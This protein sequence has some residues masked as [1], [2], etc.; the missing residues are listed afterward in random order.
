[1]KKKTAAIDT[2]VKLSP[3]EIKEKAESFG[4]R[5]DM[6]SYDDCFS[7]KSGIIAFYD[8]CL[9]DISNGKKGIIKDKDENSRSRQ[10][11][12]EYLQKTITEIEKLIE[13][14]FT[15]TTGENA[16]LIKVGIVEL[17]NRASCFGD[18]LGRIDRIPPGQ[19]PEAKT[20][21]RLK[22][23]KMYHDRILDN[24]NKKRM[25]DRAAKDEAE[26]YVND[27]LTKAGDKPKTRRTLEDWRCRSK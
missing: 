13:F 16:D 10:G 5:C 17:L 26:K 22:Y 20:P 27:I 11:E 21:I 3:S 25:K 14:L 2:P 1:M 23:G 4:L 18:T 6:E 9:I 7:L 15:I 12:I 24:V 8:S 19:K